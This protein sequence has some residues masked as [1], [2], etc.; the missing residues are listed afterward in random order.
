MSCAAAPQGVPV[1]ASAEMVMAAALHWPPG[2][3]SGERTKSQRRRGLSTSSSPSAFCPH[4]LVRRPLVPLR[5]PL[6]PASFSSSSSSASTVRS[7]L[8]RPSVCLAAVVVLLLLRVLRLLVALVVLFVL[9]VVVVLFNCPSIDCPSIN[10]PSINC[11][12][13]VVLPM[14]LRKLTSSLGRRHDARRR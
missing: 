6:R 7:F 14:A 3:G 11:P 13:S 1:R 9:F 12:T 2:P 5:R 8:V 10:C 4:F